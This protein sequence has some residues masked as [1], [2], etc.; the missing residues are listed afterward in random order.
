MLGR[1]AGVDRTAE[2]FLDGAAH[3]CDRHVQTFA[4]PAGARAAASAAA[5]ALAERA[6]SSPV[7]SRYVEA[8]EP[9]SIP[10]RAGDRTCDGREA[11]V[12]RAVPGESA[13]ERQ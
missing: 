11:G 4:G 7:Y 1:F 10:G 8:E 13:R 3:G 12:D 5:A 6:R 2:Q 9:R